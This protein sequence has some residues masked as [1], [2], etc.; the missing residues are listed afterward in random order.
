M[1]WD[2]VKEGWEQYQKLALGEWPKLTELDLTHIAGNRTQL[3]ELLQDRYDMS[4]DEA[5]Q[6]ADG[7]AE[8][9]TGD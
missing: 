5:A 1:N 2:K 8:S 9:I 6:T 4:L 7:W 3:V